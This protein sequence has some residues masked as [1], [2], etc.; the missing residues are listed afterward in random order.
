MTLK[1]DP[2]YE[3]SDGTTVNGSDVI[4]YLVADWLFLVPILVSGSYIYYRRLNEYAL[5]NWDEGTYAVLAKNALQH[6]DWL[7][8]Q[9]YWLVNA[10]DI[11]YQPYFEKPPL[12]IW[13]EAVSMAVFGVNE[14]G[15]RVPSATFTIL[16]AIVIFY[17]ATELFDRWTGF[18]GGMIFLSTPLVF[19]GNNGGRYGGVEMQFVLLGTVLTYFLLRYARERDRTFLLLAFPMGA[20]LF[21]TKGFAAGVYLIVVL[22]LLYRARSDV[23]RDLSTPASLLTLGGSLAAALAWPLYMWANFDGRFVYVFFVE[24]VLLRTSGGLT[25]TDGAVFGFMKYPYF[26]SFPIFFDPWIYFLIPGTLLLVARSFLRENR[27]EARSLL[28]LVWWIV[29][30]FSLF[31]LVGNHEWYIMPVFV[32]S[33]LVVALLFRRA[34]QESILAQAGVGLGAILTVTFSF[35]VAEYSPLATSGFPHISMPSLGMAFLLPFVMG[36]LL[37]VLAPLLRHLS[38]RYLVGDNWQHGGELFAVFV[39]VAV[40]VGFVGPPSMCGCSLHQMQHH[41]GTDVNAET[42][43][44]ET[45]YVQPRVIED[46]GYQTFSF[47][48]DREIDDA[49]VTEVNQKSDATYF[50]LLNESL[51]RIDRE[52]SVVTSYGSKEWRNVSVVRVESGRS[53]SDASTPSTVDRH[54]IAGEPTESPVSGRSFVSTPR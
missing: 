15:A 14:L 17:V 32:P 43:P 5:R 22:P 45:I 53:P 1:N 48:A 2:L 51:E 28:F 47:Y 8:L 21:L 40:T 29:S 25:V 37:V 34:V 24:Q 31:V 13:I 41:L 4:K 33:A 11:W 26:R 12:A 16:S 9:M 18:I 46:T 3:R 36:L 30:V 39:V 20:A 23:V 10:T 42:P 7:P 54:E 52:Y 19:A 44:A 49:T 27:D 6:G 35:R 50:L 38:D